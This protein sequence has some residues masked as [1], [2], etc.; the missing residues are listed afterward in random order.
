[1]LTLEGE[2]NLVCGSLVEYL[3]TIHKAQALIPH[4]TKHP[5]KPDTWEKLVDVINEENHRTIGA[6]VCDYPELTLSSFSSHR[7]HRPGSM[8]FR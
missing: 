2:W 1:M 6:A 3:P 5:N 8:E 7:G 4:T